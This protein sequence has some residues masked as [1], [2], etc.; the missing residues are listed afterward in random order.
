MD[1]LTLGIMRDF[2]HIGYALIILGGGFFII[3]AI[4]SIINIKHMTFKFILLLI[5]I[6]LISFM[7]MGAGYRLMK[8]YKELSCP[9]NPIK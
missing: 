7:M 5:T 6:L 9:T 1:P 4:L 8:Q 2:I 3:A